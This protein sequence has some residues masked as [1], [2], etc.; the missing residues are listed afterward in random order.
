MHSR[1]AKA[2]TTLQWAR[3]RLGSRALVL[4]VLSLAAAASGEA[5]TE[6][7]A[8]LSTSAE[9]AD[10]WPQW[11]GPERDGKAPAV[12][13]RW[14][15][16][17]IRLW[18]VKAGLGYSSP[19]IAGG[20]AFLHEQYSAREIL[21]ALRLRDGHELWRSADNPQALA[22][23]YS[24]TSLLGGSLGSS[25]GGRK[26]LGG[27][28]YATPL[29]DGEVVFTFGFNGVLEGR[30]TTD[31]RLLCR[32]ETDH[33]IPVHG[34][35]MSPLLLDRGTVVAHVGS[36]GAGELIAYSCAN[37][38]RVWSWSGDGPAYASPVVAEIDG[39]RQMVALTDRL[40]IGLDAASGKPLWELEFSEQS[41]QAM[42]TPLLFE[43]LVLFG[44][45]GRGTLA[46]QP[47]RRA[48]GW[49]PRKVWERPDRTF[50][51]SSPVLYRD[52]LVGLSDKRKGQLVA[53]DA[54]TGEDRFVGEGRFAESASLVSAGNHLLVLTVEGELLV[55]AWK[56]STFREIARYLVAE[57]PSWA[58]LAVSG[59]VLLIRD[60]ES[61]TAWRVAPD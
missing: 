4:A 53:I 24:V 40:A 30:S 7:S 32:L 55:L 56:G 41:N 35:A 1:G 61:L 22:D 44:G 39:S 13:E 34:T 52:M 26:P 57:T 17:L 2:D 27:G 11:R 15:E 38:D 18:S 8:T 9:D 46:L 43:D 36:G 59:D 6:Q 12:A 20:V 50:Y 29:V 54:R 16:S 21:R 5:A 42:V 45:V 51:L 19:V 49:E 60:S 47:Q 3:A 25:G 23:R 48:E 33:P 37:R 58:H 28:P 14:P 31:G 10:D